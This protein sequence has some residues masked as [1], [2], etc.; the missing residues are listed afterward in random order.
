ME[1]IEEWIEQGKR[2][3]DVLAQARKSLVEKL[4]E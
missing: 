3:L 2:R 1:A 4:T